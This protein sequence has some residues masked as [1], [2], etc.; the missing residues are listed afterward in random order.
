[1]E[2]V[3]GR[4]VVV[5]DLLEHLVWQVAKPVGDELPGRDRRGRRSW[6]HGRRMGKVALVQDALG[7]EDLDRLAG[8]VGLEPEA[9]VH[10]AL[11]V[12]ARQEV[13]LGVLEG[14]T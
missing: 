13:V 9:S 3:E 6:G 1:M 4:R 5:E 14:D 8:G 2:P 11:E 10:L 12:L 7:P